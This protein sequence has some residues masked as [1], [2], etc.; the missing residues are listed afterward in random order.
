[1]FKKII[2][3]FAASIASILPFNSAV[4]I[5]YQGSNFFVVNGSGNHE[6]E[7]WVPKKLILNGN[8]KE[9]AEVI[10]N[11]SVVIDNPQYSSNCKALFIPIDTVKNNLGIIKVAGQTIQINSLPTN[12]NNCSYWGMTNRPTNFITRPDADRSGR[13]IVIVNQETTQPVEILT[14]ERRVVSFNAC[15]FGILGEQ[16][17][18]KR[19]RYGAIIESTLIPLPTKFTFKGQE[20]TTSSFPTTTDSKVP[21]CRQIGGEAVEYKPMDW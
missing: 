20:Y 14:Q 1:M 5:Q 4:A 6:Q 2:I 19:D 3:T 13:Y 11:S 10:V 18:F 21:V 7:N 8:N 16:R 12:G 17:K 9:K 15:G